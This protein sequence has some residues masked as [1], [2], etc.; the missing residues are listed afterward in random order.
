MNIPIPNQTLFPT[1][2]MI[3]FMGGILNATAQKNINNEKITEKDTTI[4]FVSDPMPQFPGGEDSLWKFIEENLVYPHILHNVG[5]EVRVVIGFVVEK[6]GSLTDFKIIRSSGPPVLAEEALRVAKLM[7]NWIPAKIQ[8]R[9]VSTQF[10][11]PII[12]RLN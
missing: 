7:P 6:D 3:L 5:V 1:L 10:Q 8:G 11:I 12:F 4:V 9:A 2:L